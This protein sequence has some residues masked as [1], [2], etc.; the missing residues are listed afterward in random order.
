MNLKAYVAGII[1]GV[2]SDSGG[3]RYN[4]MSS[5]IGWADTRSDPCV[6]SLRPSDVYIYINKLTIIGSGNGLPRD[7]RQAILWTGDGTL[8]TRTLGTNFSEI[9]SETHTFS[10]KKMNLKM[11]SAKW[12]SSCLGHNV[13]LIARWRHGSIYL[14]GAMY[15]SGV[16]IL[17]NMYLRYFTIHES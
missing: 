2:G 7:R 11:S 6:N 17:T 12:Q 13:L 15:M 8:L 1:L 14:S 3:R 5:L 9:L 10:L 4:V 16:A